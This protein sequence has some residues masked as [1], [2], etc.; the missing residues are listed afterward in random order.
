MSAEAGAS[1]HGPTE[2]EIRELL[3]KAVSRHADHSIS[4]QTLAQAI[5]IAI[6]FKVLAAKEQ[7]LQSVIAALK[8]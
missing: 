7:L 6:D 2:E 3:A 5:M 1:S 8:S 4:H